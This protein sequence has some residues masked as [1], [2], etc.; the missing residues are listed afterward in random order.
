[1]SA[2]CSPSITNLYLK[3]WM[4]LYFTESHKDLL[5]PPPHFKRRF[6][7]AEH[8]VTSFSVTPIVSS[9]VIKAS[10]SPSFQVAHAVKVT[11]V[12]RYV[13][14]FLR[15]RPRPDLFKMAL[16]INFHLG[17][18]HKSNEKRKENEE[19]AWITFHESLVSWKDAAAAALIRAFLFHADKSSLHLQSIT[20]LL[21][22]AHGDR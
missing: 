11:V 18:W 12:V 10:T 19:K 16:I 4:F 15:D 3:W 6:S 17:H 22:C 20:R 14:V 5:P 21:M 13:Q 8:N 1:M 7:S 9:K 2:H